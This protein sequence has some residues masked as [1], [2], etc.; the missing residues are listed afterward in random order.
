MPVQYL[1]GQD[2]INGAAFDLVAKTK[3]T[4]LEIRESG[5]NYQP[6]VQPPS[7]EKG[8]KYRMM[9][10]LP[11]SSD[12]LWNN[13]KS[14]LRSQVR[15]SEKNGL[16]YIIGQ[17]DEYLDGFYNVFSLNM[18]NLGSPVHPR[19]LFESI[20]K[21][22]AQG[23]AISLVKME[24][25]VVGAGLILLMKKVATIPWASTMSEYN[26]YAP[27][28]LLYWSILKYVTDNGCSC[29][30]FGRSTYNEGTYKFK[31]QWGAQPIPL[32]WSSYTPSGAIVNIQSKSSS[33]RPIVEKIW[34]KLPLII[35]N[36][37]GPLVRK[38]ISL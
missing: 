22:Y 27:N 5:N 20:R 38:H 33:L 15:K 7:D 3:A 1:P 8:K 13:F 9:M 18:R 34:Q 14:K 12:E 31:Q 25:K 26:K 28:M 2:G 36:S 23:M 29:F 17:S 37:L 16:T 21:H 30:D 32:E 24:D 4:A 35:A 10:P 6:G 19:R 11:N